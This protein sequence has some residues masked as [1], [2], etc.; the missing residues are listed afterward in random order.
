[1]GEYCV[2]EL[3]Q[4]LAIIQSTLSHHMKCLTESAWSR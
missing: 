4:N 2:Y 1:M 3:L